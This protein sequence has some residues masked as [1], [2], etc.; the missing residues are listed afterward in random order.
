MFSRAFLRILCV[1]CPRQV[2]K[3]YQPAFRSKPSQVNC[4]F[5]KTTKTQLMNYFFF[6]F[7]YE[8]NELKN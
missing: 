7:Y 8:N 2:R 4:K 5:P 3:R 1:C 6:C